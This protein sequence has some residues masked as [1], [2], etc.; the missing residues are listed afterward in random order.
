MIPLAA[1]ARDT[2]EGLALDASVFDPEG[3]ECVSASRWGRLDDPEGLGREVARA[4]R[5]LGAERLLRRPG[6]VGTLE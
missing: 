4:L 1:W 6:T 2:L 3:R 5:D